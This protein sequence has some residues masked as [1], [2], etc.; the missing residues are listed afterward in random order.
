MRELLI[1]ALLAAIMPVGTSVSSARPALTANDPLIPAD[2]VAARC[3]RYG[4]SAW[5]NC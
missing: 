3:H 1:A 2:G 5:V 4:S